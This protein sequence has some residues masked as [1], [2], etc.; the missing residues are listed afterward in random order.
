[1][2]DRLKNFPISFFAVV[3]GLTG[4]AIA[5][6]RTERVWNLDSLISS[7]LLAISSVIFLIILVF[8]II[9][10]INTRMKF[11][12]NLKTSPNYLFSRLFPS[13]LFYFPSRGWI[14]APSYP[15]FSGTGE[16]F[17]SLFSPSPSFPS[18]FVTSPWKSTLSVRPGLFPWSAIFL[19]RWQESS[20]RLWKFTGFS[21]VPG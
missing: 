21:S 20:T 4:A 10:I 19:F 2:N 1:M 3:M 6:K 5:W 15:P 8:Y 11:G 16:R 7:T 14:T 12:K 17:C 13:A 18:G 9:K